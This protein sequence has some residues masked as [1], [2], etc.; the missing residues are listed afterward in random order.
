MAQSREKISGNARGGG[1]D[2]ALFR[3]RR[4][5]GVVLLFVGLATSGAFS[6]QVFF[7]LMP[8]KAAHLVKKRQRCQSHNRPSRRKWKETW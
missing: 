1:G 2:D 5:E 6:I 7:D 4:S 8:A 3:V